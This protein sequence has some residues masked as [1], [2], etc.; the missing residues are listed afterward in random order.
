MPTDEVAVC[1]S[2]PVA[3]LRTVTFAPAITA[4]VESMTVPLMAFCTWAF[5][6]MPCSNKASERSCVNTS[7]TPVQLGNQK[8]GLSE[9]LATLPSLVH[10]RLPGH[11]P[12]PGALFSRHLQPFHLSG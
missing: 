3:R 10:L 1:D 8:R 11:Q 2:T 6:A 7:T 9:F 5:S 4:P 12:L